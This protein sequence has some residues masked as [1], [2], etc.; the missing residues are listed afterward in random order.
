MAAPSSPA[1]FAILFIAG[2]S[3][4]ALAFLACSS[5]DTTST[6]RTDASVQISLE[7]GSPETPDGDSNGPT[8]GG[9]DAPSDAPSGLQAPTIDTIKTTDAG[10]L[11]GWT[12]NTPDCDF[13]S[14]ERKT[15][16]ES[17]TQKF[18]VPGT[19]TSTLDTT[20]LSVTNPSG[21]QCTYRLQ[22]KKGGAVSPYSGEQSTF[23]GP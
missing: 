5:D 18:N 21:S 3:P 6:P 9:S 20:S 19:T 7:S 12:N 8:E 13:V 22:C 16:L 4:L 1:R 10:V 14:G 17:Y 15:G 23:C 2:S 11:I